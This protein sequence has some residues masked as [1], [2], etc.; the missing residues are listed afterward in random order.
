MKVAGID[1]EEI[2]IPSEAKASEAEAI[3]PAPRPNW[4]LVVACIGDSITK[5]RIWDPGSRPKITRNSFPSLLGRVFEGV[6]FVNAGVTN[7]TS[8]D[9]LAR[10]GRD[11]LNQGPG[12]V[13]VEVGGNDCNVDWA[14][15]AAKPDEQHGA[16]VGLDDFRCNLA[17]IAA[18]V[19][20]AGATPIF[21]TLPPLDAGRY[22]A[23]LRRVYSDLIA[24]WICLNGGIFHWQEQYSRAVAEVAKDVGVAL[25][26][27]RARFLETADYR[28]LVSEDGLHPNEKGYL[29]MATEY[30]RVLA[31][32]GVG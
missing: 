11:A 23:F 1:D 22:Y 29:L 26:D 4:G 3:E 27:V 30:A 19:R 24:K 2:V 12:C 13:I 25:A 17:E 16:I 10:L 14:E 32:L 6:R 8:A 9:V 28:R 7:N 20:A 18:H 21:S 5:G 31:A 15:V